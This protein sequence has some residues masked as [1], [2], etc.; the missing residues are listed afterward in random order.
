MQ[1]G[2]PQRGLRGQHGRQLRVAVMEAPERASMS[3]YT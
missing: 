3:A 1:V 2:Q